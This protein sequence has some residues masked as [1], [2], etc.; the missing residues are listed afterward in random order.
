MNFLIGINQTVVSAL[1]VSK[2]NVHSIYDRIIN[3]LGDFVVRLSFDQMRTSVS[4]YFAENNII[5]CSDHCTVQREVRAELPFS[6]GISSFIDTMKYENAQEISSN[7]AYV[8]ANTEPLID[9]AVPTISKVR[10]LLFAVPLLFLRS[11]LFT[12]VWEMKRRLGVFCD[13]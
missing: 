10:Q 9:Y 1:Y 2:M 7:S 3:I 11:L 6:G 4:S 5:S 13:L 12:Q 8:F